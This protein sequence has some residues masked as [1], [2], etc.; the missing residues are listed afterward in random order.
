MIYTRISR[1]VLFVWP[2][3]AIGIDINGLVFMELAWLNFAVG[4]GA[5]P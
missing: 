4:I 2:A 5:K 1:V 3:L